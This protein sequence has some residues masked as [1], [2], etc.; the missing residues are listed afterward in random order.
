MRPNAIKYA[1]HR[2]ERAHGR[3]YVY[4]GA[5]FVGSFDTLEAACNCI[6]ARVAAWLP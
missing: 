6:L 2:I 4:D 5:H 3:Y 1:G